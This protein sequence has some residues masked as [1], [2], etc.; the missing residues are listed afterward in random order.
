MLA[1]MTI[2]NALKFITGTMRINVIP[3]NVKSARVSKS[4]PNL[5]CTFNRRAKNP[6]I[7]SV[8][9]AAIYIMINAAEN[10]S[11][12]NKVIAKIKRDNVNIFGNNLIL[13]PA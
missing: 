9:T 10:G 13:F 7:P 12:K 6:S 2:D 4:P 1:V 8:E 3:T 11:K 5:V